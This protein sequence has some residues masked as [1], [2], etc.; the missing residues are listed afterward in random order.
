MMNDYIMTSYEPK[1]NLLPSTD[2]AYKLGKYID[3]I[4]FNDNFRKLFDED[5][6]KVVDDALETIH[7]VRR[8]IRKHLAV[9]V[10]KAW[11]TVT[12]RP[13]LLT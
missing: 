11:P 6:I 10:L 13:G 3:D 1:W 9:L 8:T 7:G 2:N 5:F 12:K 4:S